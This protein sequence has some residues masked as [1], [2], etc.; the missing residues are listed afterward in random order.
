MII[1]GFS[2]MLSG[3]GTVFVFLVILIFSVILM[4]NI[5]SM[6]SKKTGHSL[7]EKHNHRIIAALTAVAFDQIEKQKLQEEVQ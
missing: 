2:I 7:Q 4:S 5:I 3:M 6:S 1:Q